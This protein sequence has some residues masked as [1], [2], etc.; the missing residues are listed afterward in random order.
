MQGEGWGGGRIVVLSPLYPHPILGAW[1]LPL[2]RLYNH[3]L[4]PEGARGKQLSISRRYT[5]LPMTLLSI[6]LLGVLLGMK[7]AFE[8]DHIA[9]VASL[10]SRHT[11]MA[12]VLRQGV[13]WGMGHSITLMIVCGGVL[14]FGATIPAHFAQGLEVVVGIML[15]ALGGEL[16]WRLR[17]EGIHIHIHHHHGHAHLHAH[18][19][20]GEGEHKYSLHRHQHTYPPPGRGRARKGVE[21]LPF[22]YSTPILPFPLKGGRNNSN[23][24]R[25]PLAVGMMH[26]LAGSAALVVLSMGVIQSP[27][28][29]ML[30]IVLFG[31]GSIIGMALLCS[32]IAIPLRL[33]AAYMNRM[34]RFLNTSVGVT[35]MLIGVG[36]VLLNGQF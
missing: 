33:S 28:W 12:D 31:I 5:Y 15:I 35:T 14:V 22:H 2:Q 23:T 3:G 8:T 7:H 27:L 4:P 6:L 30:Y 18:S 34:H 32:V 26:G 1:L 17:R 11:K 10:A 21:M 36:H 19:H 20:K 25:R 9:A 29:A 13:A 16:L 24:W